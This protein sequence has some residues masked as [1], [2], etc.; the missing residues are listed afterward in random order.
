MVRHL[1]FGLA[2]TCLTV[3]ALAVDA[4]RSV[5]RQLQQQ[6]QANPDDP[7]VMARLARMYLIGGNAERARGLYR[8]LLSVDDV[9]LERTGGAPISSHALA[10]RGLQV[11]ETPKEVRLGSR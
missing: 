11:L 4:H 6:L 2:A 10:Q 7:V 3:P 1:V 9:M 8:G 5:K